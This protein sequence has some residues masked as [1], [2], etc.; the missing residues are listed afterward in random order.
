MRSDAGSI[1][2]IIALYLALFDTILT[3]SQLKK[4]TYESMREM[5]FS[6]LQMEGSEHMSDREL[7][8]FHYKSESQFVFFCVH[9][10]MLS[11][12]FVLGY[13]KIVFEPF[14]FD[15]FDVRTDYVLLAVWQL[16]AFKDNL[17]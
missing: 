17:T 2:G 15:S 4:M 10:C 8:E 11:T 1:C 3:K 13:L 12:F 16:T 14:N 6:E 7:L 9:F 5:I